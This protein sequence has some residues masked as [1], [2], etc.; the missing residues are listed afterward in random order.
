M[1]EK[2]Q[3]LG[4]S[5]LIAPEGMFRSVIFIDSEPYKIG[6]DIDDVEEAKR[7]CISHQQPVTF[8]QVYDEKGR[9]R[10]KPT[11]KKFEFKISHT[12]PMEDISRFLKKV[13]ADEAPPDTSLL[14][15]VKSVLVDWMNV[16]PF[17]FPTTDLNEGIACIQEWIPKLLPETRFLPKCFH[18]LVVY[19][20]NEDSEEPVTDEIY[21]LLMTSV[22]VMLET[23]F[24]VTL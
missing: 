11:Y 21:T 13:I 10:L 22:T 4:L 6:E 20:I 9:S 7:K 12:E 1:S 5:G 15:A 23:E 2:L 24:K 16:I 3:A 18:T 17:I 14:V 8:I 19:L